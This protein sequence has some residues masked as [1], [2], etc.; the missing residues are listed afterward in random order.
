M[1]SP[2][3]TTSR[4]SPGMTLHHVGYAVR[5]LAAAA[6]MY[7]G[8]FGYRVATEAIHDPLQTAHVRFLRLPEDRTWLELVAPDGPASKLAKTVARRGGLH[9]LCYASGPLEESLEHLAAHGLL[10]FSQPKPAV[11]FAGRRICWLMGEDGLLVEL[12][13]RRHA[14]DRCEPGR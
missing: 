13:E 11:A 7:A 9:H 8:S 6:A 1:A 2:D 12:V 5:D 3:A 14:G 10:L 4:L